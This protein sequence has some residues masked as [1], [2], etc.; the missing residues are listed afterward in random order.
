MNNRDTYRFCD[1][2]WQLA[3]DPKP[4]RF[5]TPPADYPHT[6]SLP[7]TTA[8]QQIGEYNTAREDGFFTEKYPFEG[9]IWLRKALTL[10][11][12]QAAAPHCFLHL[13]RTR[14]TRLWVNGQFIGEEQSL[15]TPHVYDLSAQIAETMEIVICVKN[16]DYPTRGGHMT[17]PDTQTNWIGVTGKVYL[18]FRADTYIS[19]IAAYPDAAKR[20]VM[21]RGILHG[22]KQVAARLSAEVLPYV[23]ESDIAGDVPSAVSLSADDSGAFSVTIPLP[24]HAPLWSEHDPVQIA[25]T[26]ALENGESALVIFGLRDFRACSDHFEV[27]GIPT[28]LRGKHDGLVFPRTGASPTDISAWVQVFQIMKKWGIN[29]YRFHTCCPPEAAFYAADTAGIYMEPELPFWGTLKEAGEAGYDEKANAYLLREG[30]RIL[31]AFGH[32][33]SFI[34]LSLGNELWGSK[35]IMNSIIQDLVNNRNS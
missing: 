5:D 1:D 25:L 19:D 21:L 26:L 16:F 10:S 32:H 7:G 31:K 30:E 13:E 18:A 20:Q 8:Q 2:I 17:S 28:M 3:L 4:C 15:C 14:M 24:K 34:M 12:Q 33:P 22:D 35:D 23:K 29:H 6:M 11:P 27:N 9:Q